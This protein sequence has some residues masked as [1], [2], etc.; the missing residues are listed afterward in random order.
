MPAWNGGRGRGRHDKRAA[1]FWL[2]LDEPGRPLHGRLSGG[3][4]L[5]AGAA[6][7]E[8]ACPVCGLRETVQLGIV[9]ELL[10][11]RAAVIGVSTLPVPLGGRVPS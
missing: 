4:V 10:A 1:L 6:V 8:V 5:A 11:S 7:V 2:D 3:R 9:A